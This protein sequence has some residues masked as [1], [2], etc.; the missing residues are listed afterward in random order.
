MGFLRWVCWREAAARAQYSQIA[1]S[2]ASPCVPFAQT[3]QPQAAALRAAPTP[4]SVSR[5]ESAGSPAKDA[6]SARGL[7]AHW[8]FIGIHPACLAFAGGLS[9]ALCMHKADDHDSNGRDPRAAAEA[10][11]AGKEAAAQVLR[12]QLKSQSTE[13]MHGLCSSAGSGLYKGGRALCRAEAARRS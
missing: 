5:F 12:A 6:A 1:S 8:L 7:E 4:V 3:A 11:Y 9:L 10:D 2:F 13:L